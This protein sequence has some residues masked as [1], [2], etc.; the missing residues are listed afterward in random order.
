MTRVLLT[1]S[2]AATFMMLAS[3]ASAQFRFDRRVDPTNCHW[4]ETCDYGGLAYRGYR[5]H[6]SHRHACPVETV[7]RRLPDGSVVM[8]RR[9]NCAV[10]RVRG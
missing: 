4:W 5:V 2:I 3:P 9:R 10:L 1:A 8:D 7:E 6:W